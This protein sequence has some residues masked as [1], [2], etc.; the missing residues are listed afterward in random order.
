MSQTNPRI[1]ERYN[2]KFLLLLL[3]LAAMLAV[4]A[5]AIVPA[6]DHF[7]QDMRTVVLVI[8]ALSGTTTLALIVRLLLCRLRI[9]EN[10]AD[11]DNPFS[12]NTVLAWGDVRT[13]A[14]VRLRVSGTTADPIII[15]STREPAD[16]LTARALLHGKGLTRHEHVRIPCTPAR[17][18]AV[19]HYLHKSLPEYTI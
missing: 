11:V 19:E 10:G 13:A 16:V 12:G 5:A 14:I 8:F 4:C 15:L 9:D 7:G 1:D 6:W 18:A 17:L 3:V 2:K